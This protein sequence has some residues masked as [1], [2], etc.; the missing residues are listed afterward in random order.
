MYARTA[1][2]LCRSTS[3]LLALSLSGRRLNPLKLV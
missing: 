3:P 2:S 1:K